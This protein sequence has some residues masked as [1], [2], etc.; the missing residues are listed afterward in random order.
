MQT[1]ATDKNKK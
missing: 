1:S